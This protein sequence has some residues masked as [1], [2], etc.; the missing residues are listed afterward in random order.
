MGPLI[1]MGG[2]S[3]PY[4]CSIRLTIK[5]K[6]PIMNSAK[7]QIG[8]DIEINFKKNKVGTPYQVVTTKLYYG[9]GFDFENEYV[10]IAIKLG[11]IER[12]GAWYNWN[13]STGVQVKKQGVLNVVDYF[14]EVPE[15]FEWLKKTVEAK[16]KEDI[17]PVVDILDV[18]EDEIPEEE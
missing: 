5:K 2:K 7:Q 18:D 13:D 14:K 16:Q 11:I 17:P 12:G 10:D 9:K 3:L 4:Y 1:T 15:E 6:D 8:Q